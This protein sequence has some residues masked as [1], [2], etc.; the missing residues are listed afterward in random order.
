MNF[1]EGKQ[2]AAAAKAVEPQ[3]ME[4]AS[5]PQAG[6]SPIE[7]LQQGL[8]ASDD[9]TREAVLAHMAIERISACGL[10]PNPD[11]F[12]L[13][14]TYASGH[15]KALNSAIDALVRTNTLS[16]GSVRQ[17][18]DQYLSPGRFLNRVHKVSDGLR[19]EASQLTHV[20]EQAAGSAHQYR[21]TLAGASR[22]LDGPNGRQT[23]DAVV[24]ALT[25][26]TEEIIKTNAL[27]H[28]QLQASETQVQQLQQS[29]ELLQ[30]EVITDPLTATLNRNAFDRSFASIVS[31]AEEAGEPL[32]LL[33]IDIDR[34][35][36]FNERHGHQVGDD[37]LRLAAM[38]LK[39]TVRDGD[40]V[41]RLG[42]D[43]FAIILPCTPVADGSALAEKIRQTATEKQLV[44][45]ST[46]D[47]L[48][49]MSVSIGVAELADGLSAEDLFSRAD[50]SLYAAKRG[51]RD[52]VVVWGQVKG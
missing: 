2:V 15:N 18:Y 45:R 21:E 11:N 32:C 17:V 12:Q 8:A 38:M 34:F 5:A 1:P 41:A 50:S 28:A 31:A 20:L 3:P 37:V 10:A 29:L 47:T 40:L 19:G 6:A 14:Y 44:R 22:R 42:G 16:A 27:L 49:R 35:K 33:I 26:S 9:V 7:R 39:Q 46:G 30:T 25:H 24:A 13:W 51:G 52:C 48:G 36:M 23:L 4:S 43:E